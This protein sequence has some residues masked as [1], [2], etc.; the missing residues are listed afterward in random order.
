MRYVPLGVQI[1]ALF[2]GT[3]ITPQFHFT[4]HDCL[5]WQNY[6]GVSVLTIVI[7]AD[8]VLV[9]RVYALYADNRYV[10]WLVGILYAIEIIMMILGVFMGVPYIEV[11]DICLATNMPWTYL[12][13]L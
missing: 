12:F 4:H 1:S 7:L 9:L 3:E 11:D 8:T 2:I 6:L 13:F 10:K 5:I